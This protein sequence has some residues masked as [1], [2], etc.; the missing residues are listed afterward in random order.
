MLV[1][2]LYDVAQPEVGFGGVSHR[3][4]ADRGA[5]GE[6]G[7]LYAHHL[8]VAVPGDSARVSS[9]AILYQR[10]SANVYRKTGALTA[11]R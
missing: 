11:K 8:A 6:S 10:E 2:A 3:A 9:R 4:G 1:S 7:E 5:R